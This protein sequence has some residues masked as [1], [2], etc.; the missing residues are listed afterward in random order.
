MAQLLFTEASGIAL[1]Q[2]NGGSGAANS[3]SA[4]PFATAGLKW[5][6]ICGM[7]ELTAEDKR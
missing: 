2:Y 1:E 3:P 7:V 5:P 4:F 6:R